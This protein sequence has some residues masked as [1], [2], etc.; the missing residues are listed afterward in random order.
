[1]QSK[2]FEELV[3]FI[4]NN[5]SKN[6]P[7][8]NNRHMLGVCRIAHDIMTADCFATTSDRDVVTV[9]AM[10]HDYGHTGGAQADSVNIANAIAGLEQFWETHPNTAEW[11]G[12]YKPV[13]EDLIRV[14]EYP[15]VR[16]PKTYAEKVLRDADLLYACMS[17]DTDVIMEGLRLEIIN[18]MRVSSTNYAY[19]F[20][21][22]TINNPTFTHEQMLVAQREF[23]S[24]A[25][26]YTT[27]GQ[28]YWNFYAPLYLEL[29]ENA[30]HSAIK[31]K[32]HN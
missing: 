16:E 23:A 9:A 13:I 1:M 20:Q 32:A 18:R 27:A 4:H 24:K 19:P 21:T 10:L 25:M 17:L 30:A 5:P 7:Y 26:L 12:P 14:T 22:G 15:F 3:H 31:T 8:H 11:L 6:L 29:L 2:V 28:R